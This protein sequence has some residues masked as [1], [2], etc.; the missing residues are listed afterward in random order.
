MTPYRYSNDKRMN[1]ELRSIQ[2]AADPAL[3]FLTK[4]E[5][6]KGPQKPSYKGSFPPNRFNIRPGYRWDGVERS[7]GFEARYF[8]KK[9]QRAHRNEERDAFGK[10]DM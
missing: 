3:R 1:D 8:Q 5:V 7:N 10:E 2:R 6:N 4:K 9:H